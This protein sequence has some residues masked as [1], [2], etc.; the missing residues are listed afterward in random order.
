MSVAKTKPHTPA[1]AGALV[2]YIGAD[3]E[4]GGGTE[5]RTEQGHGDQG[6]PK[7]EAQT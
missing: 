3:I 4:N 2:A 5:W 6:G 1:G 7:P